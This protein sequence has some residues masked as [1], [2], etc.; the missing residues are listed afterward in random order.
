[1]ANELEVGTRRVGDFYDFD[2]DTPRVQVILERIER[3]ICITLPWSEPASP[4]AAWFMGDEIRQFSIDGEPVGEPKPV[5]RRVVFNDSHGPVLLTRCWAKGFHA[6]MWGPGSG[7]LWSRAAILGV[8]EDI[9]YDRPHGLKTEISGLREWLGISSWKESYI[10]EPKPLTAS[11]V[12]Q[13]VDPIDL[14]EFNGLSMTLVPSWKVTPGV[15][16]DNRVLLDMLRCT[17]R[18]NDARD[19][20]EHRA[21]HFALRDLL[22]V[23]RWWNET[24]VEVFATRDDDPFRALDGKVHGELWR[25]VVV[26]N[27]ERQAPPTGQR[28]HLIRFGELG[29][30]GIQSWFVLR[31][32]FARAL[33]PVITSR[34]LKDAGGHTLLAHT[35]PGLEALGYLLLVQDGKTESAANSANLKTRFTRIL[36]DLGDCLPFDGPTWVEETADAYNGIKHAN[37][38]EPD[39]LDVL[40]AWARCVLVVRAWVAAELG[41]PMEELKKRLAEDPQS[42][43]YVKVG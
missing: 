13:D 41:V 38:A 12:S 42:H 15:G 4:Y 31:E 35:G 10:W 17:T 32:K 37:R 11:L 27:D 24:C 25:D 26:P 23:S 33:D 19:W 43:G 16:R 7:V 20:S 28:A 6:G 34:G 21:H 3:G 2:D 9:E 1:M 30:A 40:N 18:S 29:V 39:E 36:A 8:D 14:G 22:V 5:P